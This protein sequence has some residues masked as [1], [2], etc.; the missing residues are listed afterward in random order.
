MRSGRNVLV[1][2]R[3]DIRID[4][5]SDRRVRLLRAGDFVDVFQLGFALDVKAANA[6][7]DCIRD[8]VDRF[9]DSREGALFRIGPGFDR[10]EK[11]A[12]GNDVESCARFGE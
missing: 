6:L 12:A 9:A 5:D 4:P 2:V 11:F 3:I 8:F 1:R 10:A 7:V